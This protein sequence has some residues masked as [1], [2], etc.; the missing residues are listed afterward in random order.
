M[1]QAGA[2]KIDKLYKQDGLVLAE[3]EPFSSLAFWEG[4]KLQAVRINMSFIYFLESKEG[5]GQ[6][7]FKID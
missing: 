4:R 5:T 1:L 3:A 2:A 6:H 7:A